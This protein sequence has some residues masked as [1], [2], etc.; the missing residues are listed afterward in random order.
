MTI[1]STN[2]FQFVVAFH[3][4]GPVHKGIMAASSLTLFRIPRE[5]EPERTD[6]IDIHPAS[7]DFFQFN[8]VEPLES[9]E[10]RFAEWLE[11][12]L[13]IALSEWQRSIARELDA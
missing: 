2:H 6:P 8:Y 4:I 12:S 5:E 7:P 1:H 3:G 10:A 9:I 11:S 13:A